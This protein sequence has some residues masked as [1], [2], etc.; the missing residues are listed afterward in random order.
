LQGKKLWEFKR[1]TGVGT[2]LQVEKRERG[3]HWFGHGTEA[4][5]ET[6]CLAP[7]EPTALLLPDVPTEVRS[8]Q[9]KISA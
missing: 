3:Q 5:P 2:E 9:K 8:V 6:V 1:E 7:G 4:R